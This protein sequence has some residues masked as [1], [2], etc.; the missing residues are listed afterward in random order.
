MR[1]LLASG[2]EIIPRDGR[3]ARNAS[4]AEVVEV[5]NC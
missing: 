4:T 2:A 1:A 5:I 3:S